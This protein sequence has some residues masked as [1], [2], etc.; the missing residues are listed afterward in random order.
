MS[1]LRHR[2]KHAQIRHPLGA[3]LRHRSHAYLYFRA[4]CATARTDRHTNCDGG[5][6]DIRPDRRR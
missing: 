5:E 4:A 2:L 3:K 6:I 1:G